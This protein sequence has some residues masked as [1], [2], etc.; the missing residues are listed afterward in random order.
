MQLLFNYQC[1]PICR[2][3]TIYFNIGLLPSKPTVQETLTDLG[4]TRSAWATFG[5]YGNSSILKCAC[6]LSLPPGDETEQ[7]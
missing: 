6:L 2:F 4:P 7:V 5:G 1:L 3:C